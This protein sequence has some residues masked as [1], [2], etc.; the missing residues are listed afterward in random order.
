MVDTYAMLQF[1]ARLISGHTEAAVSVRVPVTISL[2]EIGRSTVHQCIVN[3]A[4]V[5]LS[6]HTFAVS[7]LISNYNFRHM[8]P[9]NGANYGKEYIIVHSI[10]IAQFFYT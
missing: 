5:H 2:A 10:N 1:L 4:T 8:M 6:K 3:T 9:Q 7:S